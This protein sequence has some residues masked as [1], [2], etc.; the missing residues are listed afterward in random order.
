MSYIE[1]VKTAL[2]FFPVIAFFITIPYM[3]NQYHKYGSILPYKT[4][5]I[6][7]F[8]LY[9]LIAYFLIIL[10]LPDINEVKLLTTPRVN[11]Q[12][13][14][15]IKDFIKE[16]GLVLSD[17][18][19]YYSAI[20]KSCF[21]VPLYN[22]F[23]CM[24]FG[25]Y[26]HYYFKC[27]LKKTFIL[28]FLLSLFFELTQLTGLY[29]IY[30]RGYR[31]FDVDDLLLN[32]LG[33]LIGYFIAYLF[34]KFLPSRESIDKKSYE[35]GKRIS[36]IKRFTVF[37]LDAVLYLFIITIL[38]ITTNKTYFVLIGIVYFILIPFL[39]KGMT[40]GKKFLNLKVVCTD[41]KKLSI[42]RLVIREVLFVL[43]YT[44]LP[45]LFIYLFIISCNNFD[46]STKIKVILLII[47]AIIIFIYYIYLLIKLLRKKSM[48]FE[49]ASHTK[50]I[51]TIDKK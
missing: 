10:P 5:I 29:F 34:M 46:I 31:L 45:I 23:L 7:S 25:I 4:G 36:I 17:F 28:T 49:L 3:L 37:S 20:K 6:Y 13:F 18:T 22:L 15:F 42:I 26:L 8:V 24:P 47:I 30:P 16:S 51:S 35:Y 50:L 38:Y 2:V 32:T 27:N 48:L 40:F 9:L 21:Y 43:T 12:L 33:G 39:L 19:T 41:E 1:I 44:G 14:S 11:L